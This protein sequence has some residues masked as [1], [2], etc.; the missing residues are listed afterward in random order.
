MCVQN[1]KFIAL[2]VPEIIGD[3]RQKIGSPWIRPPWAFVRMDPVN[4]SAKFEVRTFT[5]YRDNSD[6]VIEVLGGVANPQSWGRGGH[7]RSGM[8]PFKRAL[9]SSYR[10]AIVTFPLSLRVSEILP[11]LCSSTPLFPT[12]L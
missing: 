4:V 5:R 9:V 10:P 12:H 11:L 6:S 2:P 1:L 8:V 3:T 7:S